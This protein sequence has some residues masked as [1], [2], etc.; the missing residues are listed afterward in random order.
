[1][2]LQALQNT[3]PPLLFIPYS[4]LHPPQATQYPLLPLLIIPTPPP[5][6]LRKTY[7]EAFENEDIEGMATAGYEGYVA[8]GLDLG[9]TFDPED[10][11]NHRYAYVVPESDWQVRGRRRTG[12]GGGQGGECRPGK[13]LALGCPQWCPSF[14]L[15][16]SCPS[17]L[18][19]K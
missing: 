18:A 16:L 2:S 13:W 1:M 8:E 11:T 15:E 17:A 6:R 14:P 3:P 10:N 5:P 4:L 12:G 19:P 7:K 9:V